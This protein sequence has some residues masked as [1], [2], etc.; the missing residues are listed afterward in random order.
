MR[1]FVTVNFAI[2]WDGRVST[3]KLTPADFT[4]K[5]DKQR[6]SEIRATGDAVLVGASTLATDRMTM[7]ISDPAL[8]AARV[9]KRQPPYPLRVIVSNSGRISPAL[10]VFE[11]DF[12]PILIFTTQKMPRA[13][14]AALL[15]LAD[16]YVSPGERV[17]LPAMLA[18][19]R[20]EYRVKRLV[21]E[22]GPRLL[23]SLLAENLVDEIHFTLAPRIFGGLRAPTLTGLPGDFLPRS[24]RCTLREMKVVNGECFLRYR[25][26]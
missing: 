24:T 12:S 15:C 17:D 22:G 8:R 10:R 20:A 2:T 6:L 4:S 19:L 26:V 21:C 13:V 25:V 23:R 5:R 3:R 9:A 14:R 7:G 18:T 11:K 1:P 16:L